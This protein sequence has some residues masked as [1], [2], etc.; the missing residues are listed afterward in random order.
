M[1][2]S[3]AAMDAARVRLERAKIVTSVRG[4]VNE[5]MV[6]KGEYVQAGS[7]VAEVVDMET[8][9]VTVQVPEKDI[10]F[11]EVGEEA[12]V[13][14]NARGN[15]EKFTGK[16]SY[17][18]ELA[19]EQTRSTRT[20]ITVD[21]REGQLRSGQIV[22]AR[23]TRRVIKDVIMIPL[24]AVIPLEEGKAVY[25]VEEGK[26]VRREVELGLIRGRE[27][28]VLSGLESGDVLIIAW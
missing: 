23:L 15:S 2:L 24:L 10:Q 13:S 7:A 28:Q 19:H 8:A 1:A 11:L 3:K 16:I 25:V 17:I 26:A 9:K 21:N 5:L 27:V 14:A 18:S 20:E 4:V 12:K 6:E 22:R